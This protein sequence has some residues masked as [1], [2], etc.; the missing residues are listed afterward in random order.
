M[1]TKWEGPGARADLAERINLLRGIAIIAVIAIHTSAHFTYVEQLS[2]VVYAVSVV[3]VF[4]HFAVPLFVFLSGITLTMRYGPAAPISPRSFYARRLAKI[5]PPYIVFSFLYLVLFAAEYHQVPAAP[6]VILALATGGAYY[7]LWFV[8]L[9]VQLYLL[10]PLLRRLL[11][12]ARSRAAI[13]RLLFGALLLQL[14]WNIGAPLLASAL[15]S[16]P[17][18]ETLL[19]NRVFLSHVFY[20]MLGMVAGANITNFD[21][22]VRALPTVALALTIAALVAGTSVVWILAMQRYGRLDAAPAGAFVASLAVEP[23]LFVASIVLA[24]QA[25]ARLS[26]MA[27]SPRADAVRAGLARLGIL[28]LPIYLVHVLLQW[29]LRRSLLAFDLTPAVWGFYPLMFVLTLLLSY[30]AARLFARLPYG[31]TLTGAPSELE[32]WQALPATPA[33]DEA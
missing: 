25:C 20:F 17:L 5:V 21:R 22:R 9:L 18:V 26:Q 16:R 24:W 8:A 3:D 33:P 11:G 30:T 13:G 29:L 27:R 7:H 10:F 23:L 32:G 4:A 1:Q 15:P 2:P 19:S 12:G 14:A 31:E 28:S 6:W